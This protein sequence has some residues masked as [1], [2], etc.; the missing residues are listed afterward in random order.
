MKT[1]ITLVLCHKMLRLEQAG[2]GL[3]AQLNTIESRLYNIK[4]KALKFCYLPLEYE[5]LIKCNL[6]YLN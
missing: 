5:N 6:D 3:Q 4:N 2:E 1:K